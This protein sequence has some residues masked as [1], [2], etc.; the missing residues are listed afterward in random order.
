[1]KRISAIIAT[2]LLVAGLAACGSSNGGS[3]ASNSGSTTGSSDSKGPI[4]LMVIGD[5]QSSILSLPQIQIGAEA[6]AK[7]INAAGGVNGHK[8]D[9]LSCNSQANVNVAASCASQAVADHV[10]AVVS[11]LTLQ[12]TGVWPGLQA[13]GIPVIGTEAVLPED[14][15]NA[16]S[17]AIESTPILQ[18]GQVLSMPGWQQCKRPGVLGLSDNPLAL[19]DAQK[20]VQLYKDQTPSVTAKMVNVT[21]TT[22]DLQPAVSALLQGGT[23]CV[24][25]LLTPTGDLSV[26]QAVGTSGQK[27]KMGVVSA[28]A[29]LAN[30]VQIGA[31]AQGVYVD[32]LFQEPGT[33]A[34]ASTFVSEMKSVDPSIVIDAVGEASYVG[35]YM[36]AEGTKSL[37]NFSPSNV[38]KAM[39]SAGV[40]TVPLY[41]P[42][43]PFTANSGLPTLTRVFGYSVYSYEFKGKTL[44]PS[45]TS[46][47]Q[48]PLNIRSAFSQLFG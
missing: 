29:P 21:T 6:A 15:N 22:T 46:A 39:N 34:A 35:V 8:I 32:T 27:V 17:Y 28:D 16:L 9:M 14:A 36:F 42:V 43:G 5:F 40:I 47:S 24:F 20:I 4:K 41:G 23:D 45:Y 26:I 18:I 33:S 12:G 3:G 48:E 1:L 44:V 19:E 37:S 25:P 38:V 13:A 30:L 31:A 11:M 10:S 2:G 7:E